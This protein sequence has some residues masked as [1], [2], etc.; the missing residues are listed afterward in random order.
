MTLPSNATPAFEKDTYFIDNKLYLLKNGLYEPL[1]T[2]EE[3]L[4]DAINNTLKSNDQKD[5]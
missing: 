3:V 2:E 4:S 5:I 1:F